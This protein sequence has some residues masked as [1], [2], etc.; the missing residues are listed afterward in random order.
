MIENDDMRGR[1]CKT[2]WRNDEIALYPWSPTLNSVLV[3]LNITEST[4]V[5]TK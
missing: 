4:V 1:V 5:G 3:S 2:K